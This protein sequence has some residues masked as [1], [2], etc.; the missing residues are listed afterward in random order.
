MDTA[1]RPTTLRALVD[2]IAGGDVDA[3]TFTSAPAVSSLLSTAKDVGR[4]DALVRAFNGPVAAI[5]VG[6]VTA[7]PLTVLGVD[8]MQPTRS[9]LGSMAKYI[10]EELPNR[11]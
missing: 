9:R 3:V 4:V 6:S 11:R 7:S 8:T 10:I 5:C 2:G 1:R